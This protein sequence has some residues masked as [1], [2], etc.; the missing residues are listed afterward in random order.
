MSRGL[1]ARQK[2]ILEALAVH[3]PM[4]AA[5]VAN[6]TGIERRKAWDVLQVLAE[7][8]QTTGNVP[9][10]TLRRV[11]NGD[12][13]CITHASCL[14][15]MP[16]LAVVDHVITDPPYDDFALPRRPFDSGPGA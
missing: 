13:A 4:T 16:T 11:A 1:G 12:E 7:R 2:K 10:Y 6:V 15:V 8:L 9:T 5:G 3:G 14:D